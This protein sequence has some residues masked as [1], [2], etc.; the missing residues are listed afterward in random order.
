MF[1]YSWKFVYVEE[2]IPGEQFADGPSTGILEC[3][4]TGTELL[5]VLKHDLVRFVA[6][7]RQHAVVFPARINASRVDE[8]DQSEFSDG[9][10]ILDEAA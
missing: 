5:D 4:H 8:F 10:Q 7:H 6:A 9:Q 1:R 2:D 3:P